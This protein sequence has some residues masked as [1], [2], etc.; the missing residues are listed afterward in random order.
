MTVN[1]WKT[2][3][4]WLLASVIVI[5]NSEWVGFFINQ[6][7]ISKGVC[8]AIGVSNF[9]VHHLEQLKEDCSVTPHV[10]QVEFFSQ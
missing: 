1:I 3:K 7:F 5:Y 10:N 8:R 6:S 4:K 2:C 9:L